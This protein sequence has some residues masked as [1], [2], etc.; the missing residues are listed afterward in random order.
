MPT[1]SDGQRQLTLVFPAPLVEAVERTAAEKGETV[2]AL[3]RRLYE[4][5]TGV[6]VAVRGRGR[7]RKDSGK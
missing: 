6:K 4:R 7:P 5:L 1:L 2:T 3:T